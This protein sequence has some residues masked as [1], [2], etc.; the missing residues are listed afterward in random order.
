MLDR[1]TRRVRVIAQGRAIAKGRAIAQPDAIARP[2]ATQTTTLHTYTLSR[3]PS[4]SQSFNL[5]LPPSLPPSPSPSP[6][7][8]P[9]LPLPPLYSL[10][11]SLSP[12]PSPTLSPPGQRPSAAQTATR[13]PTPLHGDVPDAQGDERGT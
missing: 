12:S 7:P 2:S 8:F 13:R 10:P 11:I 3:P 4:L 1:G 9:S 6:S 5:F